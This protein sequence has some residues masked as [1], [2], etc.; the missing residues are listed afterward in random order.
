MQVRRLRGGSG[1]NLSEQGNLVCLWQGGGVGAC[2]ERV[3]GRTM[4]MRLA[5]WSGGGYLS[6]PTEPGVLQTVLRGVP[7]RRGWG[8][9]WH[10]GWNHGVGQ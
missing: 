8:M 2:C 5:G 6:L 1:A 7:C 10:V 4:Q 3:G 9:G